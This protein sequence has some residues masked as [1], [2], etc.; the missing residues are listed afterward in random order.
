MHLLLEKARAEV[1]QLFQRLLVSMHSLAK[2]VW[3][4]KALLE[5]CHPRK[6]SKDF[7]TS[8]SLLCYTDHCVRATIIVLLKRVSRTTGHASLQPQFPDWGRAVLD[9]QLLSSKRKSYLL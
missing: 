5:K 3:F 4:M 9:S 2:A 6:C 7:N 8:Q 1:E